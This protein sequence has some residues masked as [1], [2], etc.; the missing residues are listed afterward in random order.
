MVLQLSACAAVVQHTAKNQT[1][2]LSI[3]QT[4]QPSASPKSTPLEILF[5]LALSG[6]AVNPPYPG[7]VAY[8]FALSPSLDQLLDSIGARGGVLRGQMIDSA[9]GF[10]RDARGHHVGPLNLKRGEAVQIICANSCAIAGT[11]SVH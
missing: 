11:A 6:D 3:G 4:V 10:G 7:G 8:F 2:I 9:D 1:G 5:S